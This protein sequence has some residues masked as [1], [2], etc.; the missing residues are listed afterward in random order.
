MKNNN[1]Y[2]YSVKQWNPFVGCE[3]DCLYCKTSF[4]AQLKRYGKKNCSS[5]YQYIPHTHPERLMQKLPKTNY[6]QFIFTCA[7]GDISF[8]PRNYME[9][10]LERIRQESGK[11]FL[12]QT[13]NPAVLDG[14]VFPKNMVLGTTIETN[15]D[16]GYSVF[17]R[18]PL[19]SQ[20][21]QDFLKI[22]HPLKIVTVE[23]VM[24]FDVD[25]MIDW[26]ENIR[27]CMI[28]LGFDSKHTGMLPE[29][30]IDK[31]RGLH[32]ELSRKGFVV[33]LK[34]IREENAGGCGVVKYV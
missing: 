4:Q 33:I 13:K 29:P 28:W 10:I 22:R 7:S 27:P 3:Y 8:C 18:A 23:P 30:S 6:M 5:C 21:Y 11:T 31:V 12:L 24:D 32:W 1:M 14:M 9:K 20:R 19:P 26:V 17:S 15:R 16:S 2:A 25:V 34:T